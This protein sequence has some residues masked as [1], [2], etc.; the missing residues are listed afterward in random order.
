M[1]GAAFDMKNPAMQLAIGTGVTYYSRPD[2]YPEPPNLF[3]PY[4]RSTLTRI[5]IDRPDPGDPQRAVWDAQLRTMLNAT[6]QP[7]S[8]VTWDALTLD[9]YKGFE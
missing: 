6:G 3:A 1:P 7:E 5:T 4:W 2:H 9:D 8:A